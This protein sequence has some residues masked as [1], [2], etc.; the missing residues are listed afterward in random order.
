MH[1]LL[2]LSRGIDRIT[3]AIGFTVSWFIL[4]AVL[5]SAANA[6]VRKAFDMSSN[7]W[8]EAQWYLFSAVF[9]LA[10]AYTLQRDDHIRIDVVSGMLS[11]R[12]RNWIDLFGHFFMLTPFVALMIYHA[13]PFVT[14]S[15]KQQ[16][17]SSNAGGLIV[18]PAKALVLAGFA[19]LAM[20]AVSEIIKRIA[21][22]RGVIPDPHIGGH[23]AHLEAEALAQELAASI[24][25]PQVRE[26]K[27]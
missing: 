19:L 2:G 20:Q 12:V 18:W 25:K 14:T 6:V 26:P 11:R 1:F 4:A 10:A 8:L 24:I 17:S 27:P 7:A 5:I 23:Q 21:I 9:L 16:E 22:M 3:A 13:I 15:Y